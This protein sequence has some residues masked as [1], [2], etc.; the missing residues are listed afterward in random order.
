M[1]T[2]TLT[3]LPR[4]HSHWKLGGLVPQGDE[5]RSAF[6]ENFDLNDEDSSGSIVKEVTND[7]GICPT[8]YLTH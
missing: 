8:T 4:P 1:P 3:T 6:F 2:A 7:E 5:E